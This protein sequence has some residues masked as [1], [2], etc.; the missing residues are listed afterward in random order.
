MR[1][2]R[3]R[4]EKARTRTGISRFLSRP[5]L[6]KRRA[7]SSLRRLGTGPAEG[8]ATRSHSAFLF[9]SRMAGAPTLYRYLFGCCDGSDG[10]VG[11]WSVLGARASRSACA[12]AVC[13][14]PRFVDITAES[15]DDEDRDGAHAPQVKQASKQKASESTLLAKTFMLLL[16]PLFRIRFF[17]RLYEM[18]MRACCSL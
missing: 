13:R 15:T 12:C 7:V 10:M 2:G 9:L 11:G 5:P 18:G 1:V 16:G 6:A 14:G 4:C 8:T 3:G 17:S